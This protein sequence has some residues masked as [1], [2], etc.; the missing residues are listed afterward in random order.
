MGV[1]ISSKADLDGQLCAWLIHFFY[2]FNKDVITLFDGDVSHYTRKGDLI[3]FVDA[4]YPDVEL[5]AQY[6]PLCKVILYTNEFYD[7]LIRDIPKNL[8][9]VVTEKSLSSAVFHHMCISK[10]PELWFVKYVIRH[11][12]NCQI[13]DRT[14]HIIEKMMKMSLLNFNSFSTL[15]QFGEEYV[16]RT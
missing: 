13:D 5:F 14:T 15:S 2:N 6:F 1:I 9:V 10:L 12:E 11:I 7:V 16:T 4:Q 3:Y 8:R